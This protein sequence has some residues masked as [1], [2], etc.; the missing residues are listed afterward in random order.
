MLKKLLFKGRTPTSPV[1]LR[2]VKSKTNP[3]NFGD[4]IS[5]FNNIQTIFNSK[6][7]LQ[8]AQPDQ[9][10][11]FFMFD[12]EEPSP[13]TT[14]TN[15]D[16]EDSVSPTSELKSSIVHSKPMAINMQRKG[17]HPESIQNTFGGFP[18]ALQAEDDETIFGCSPNRGRVK[19]MTV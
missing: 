14:V 18:A 3:E 1:E 19:T 17:F 2:S 9:S 4:K 6:A 8:E 5:S 10:E 16:E 11:A 15:E 7:N 12:Q 13:T